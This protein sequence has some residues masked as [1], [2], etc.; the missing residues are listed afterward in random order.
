MAANE[1]V[2]FAGKAV[3]I[4]CTDL[5]KS[6]HF[7]E[8]VLGAVRD[9]RDGFGCAWLRLGPLV[10]TLMPNAMERS[11]AEFPAHAMPMLWLEADDLG[12][13]HKHLVRHGVEIVQPPDGPSMLIADPDG[14]LIEVWQAANES[15]NAP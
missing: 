5:P 10:L 14:V 8:S 12:A 13:A 1:K 11:P 6:R 7:Y 2:A 15:G 9:P 3:T 4:A